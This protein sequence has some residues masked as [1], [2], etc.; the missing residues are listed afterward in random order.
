[1]NQK[2]GI[3]IMSLFLRILHPV[4]IS[5]VNYQVLLYLGGVGKAYLIKAF[6]FSL[7]I[8]LPPEDVLLTASTEAVAANVNGASYYSALDFGNNGNQPVRQVTKSR[9][10]IRR[11]SF[12]TR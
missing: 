10:S 9:L 2:Q 7:S 6:M 11:S 4:H 1:M 5:S 8:M 12:S 3:I